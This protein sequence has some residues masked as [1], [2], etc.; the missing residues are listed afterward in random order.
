[1]HDLQG[2]IIYVNEAACEEYGS[3]KNEL[4]GTNIWNLASVKEEKYG[5]PRL[6][7]LREKG[8]LTFEATRF[9]RNGS[10]RSIQVKSVLIKLGEKEIIVSIHRNITEQKRIEEE[11]FES[12]QRLTDLVVFKMPASWQEQFF[13][14]LVAVTH[15][16]SDE[17]LATAA[18][19][20]R[21]KTASFQHAQVRQIECSFAGSRKSSSQ[22][23]VLLIEC[24]PK[25]GTEIDAPALKRELH[26]A[27]C[28]G[29]VHVDHNAVWF[30]YQWGHGADA[31]FPIQDSRRVKEL[32]GW[33]NR[34]L[35]LLFNHL[36]RRRHI[37]TPTRPQ[38]VSSKPLD[39]QVALE[40]Y[41]EDLLVQQWDTLPW[42]NDLEYLDRQVECGTLG[43]LDILARDRTSGD[44]VVIEIK[45][46]Q[47][48]DEVVGQ[49][50][51]Y[52]GWIKQH[53]ADHASVGV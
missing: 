38:A 52:M 46:D 9:C 13:E 14:K 12:R 31:V 43:M 50:S 36:E 48:G 44:Y 53:R 1:M 11:L 49:L 10:K 2:N 19:H 34:S 32:I 51:R 26:D 15:D 16:A 5:G 41:L 33:A 35:S 8:K 3:G 6:Q 40:Q 22:A 27:G 7:S 30:Q 17:R 28:G 39:L 23:Q 4:I 37:V 42:A 20:Q 24:Q 21:K 25:R 18:L 29:E 47:G 45:R